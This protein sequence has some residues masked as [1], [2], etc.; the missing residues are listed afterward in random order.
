[1]RGLKLASN[2]NFGH[3]I[4]ITSDSPRLFATDDHLLGTT[5]RA[6]IILMFRHFTHISEERTIKQ[7]LRL[8]FWDL[9]VFIWVFHGH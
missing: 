8:V 6:E 7:H 3:F 5:V 9:T 1:M 2:E 4:K